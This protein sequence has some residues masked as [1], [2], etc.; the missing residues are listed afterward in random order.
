M[1][2]EQK[3]YYTRLTEKIFTI[4]AGERKQYLTDLKKTDMEFYERIEYLM[5]FLTIYEDEIESYA[6]ERIQEIL[7]DMP[8]LD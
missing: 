1:N 3:R 4:P 8:R 7:S 5:R 2:E 6:K